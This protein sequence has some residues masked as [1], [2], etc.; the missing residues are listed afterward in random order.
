MTVG[1]TVQNQARSVV[2][3]GLQHTQYATAQPFERF[4]SQWTPLPK[5][6]LRPPPATELAFFST[7]RRA[8]GFLVKV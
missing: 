7:Q 2:A 6:V 1:F 5:T 3:Q 8:Q 4:P